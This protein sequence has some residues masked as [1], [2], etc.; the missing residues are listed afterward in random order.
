[1]AR[2]DLTYPR[3][4]PDRA[5]ED[6]RTRNWARNAT[7]APSASVSAPRDEDELRTLLAT[8]EGGVRVIGSRMSPGRMLALA[9]QGDILLDLS[10]L[11]GLVEIGDDH[12]TFGAATTRPAG[13][14]SRWTAASASN[15]GTPSSANMTATV[16]L[17]MPIDP[18]RPRTIM[19]PVFPAGHHP[20][21]DRQGLR[22]GVFDGRAR[23]VPHPRRA[24]C[25]RRAW[26]QYPARP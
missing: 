25:G 13:P 6:V 22:F 17:P 26:F 20:P 16:D 10:H 15:T 14:C 8:T 5:G 7:L 19:R 1:M 18:V 12:A 9:A 11:R 24:Q 2:N 3:R 21:H 23:Q 4:E